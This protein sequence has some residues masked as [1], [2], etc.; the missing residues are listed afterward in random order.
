MYSVLAC[1]NVATVTTLPTI[2][3]IVSKCFVLFGYHMAGN[4]CGV[5][6][7]LLPRVHVQGVKQSVLSVYHRRRHENRQIWGFKCLFVL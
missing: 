5:L 3:C 1:K 4:V 6:F 2:T 7:Q